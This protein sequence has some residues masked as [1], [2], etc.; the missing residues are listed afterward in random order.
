MGVRNGKNYLGA[1]ALVALTAVITLAIGDVART[2]RSAPVNDA[3][4]AG[5]IEQLR[6]QI[7]MVENNQVAF[8]AS[9]DQKFGEAKA[10]SEQILIEIRR[11]DRS[12]REHMTKTP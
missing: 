8:K 2:V 1:L 4:Q 3:I 11:L 12:L 5:Q 6:L 9:V 10:D 7:K